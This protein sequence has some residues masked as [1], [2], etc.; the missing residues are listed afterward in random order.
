M[1]D[2]DGEMIQ[3]V[4]DGDP[5]WWA[6][7]GHSITQKDAFDEVR[8]AEDWEEER[9]LSMRRAWARWSYVGQDRWGEPGMT[10]ATYAEPA[11]G[12]FPITLIEDVEELERIQRLRERRVRLDREAREAVAVRWPDAAIEHVIVQAEPHPARVRMRVPGLAGPVDW[13][14]G[15]ESVWIQRRDLDAWQA[16]ESHREPSNDL[17]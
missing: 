9:R 15:A 14:H 1:S 7:R 2:C 16:R 4:W 5:D 13:R 11:Q 12:R 6:F 8:E 17:G 10:L 3:M